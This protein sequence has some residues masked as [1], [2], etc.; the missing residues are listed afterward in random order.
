MPTTSMNK[1]FPTL[2]REITGYMSEYPDS[3]YANIFAYILLNRTGDLRFPK[4]AEV[5]GAVENNHFYTQKKNYVRYI[6]SRVDDQSEE[7]SLLKQIANGDINLSI[8]HI[9]PQTLSKSWKDSLGENYELLHQQYVDTLPNLT[10][11]GY[12]SK[13]SNNDFLKKKTIEDGFND[14]PLI[15]NQ[16][17]KK[18]DKWDME[19]IKEREKW[20]LEQISKIW[21]VP[22]TSFEP[23][24]SESEAVFSE[25]DLTGAKIKGVRIFG[26]EF[27]CNSCISAY[28]IIL[29]KLFELEENLYDLIVADEFLHKFIKTSPDDLNNA[30]ELEGTPYFF[31]C[32]LSNNYKRDVIARMLELLEVNGSEIKVILDKDKDSL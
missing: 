29:K 13:Y 3:N 2:H 24:T 19:S 10:L 9:M 31:E 25:S 20:W 15:I 27:E 4:E 12:N 21:P 30:G 5:Q 14:S 1:F 6:L 32:R 8:E 28:E 22:S 7:S 23:D 18:I 16:Y 17:L 11:T 26:E